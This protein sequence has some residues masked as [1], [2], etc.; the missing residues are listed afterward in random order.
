LYTNAKSIVDS[1]DAAKQTTQTVKFDIF[2][3]PDNVD[4][5]YPLPEP[6]DQVIEGIA[7][8][9]PAET[10]PAASPAPVLLNPAAKATPI[11]PASGQ[12]T[13]PP[14]VASI[15][16]HTPDDAKLFWGDSPVL[17]TGPIRYFQSSQLPSGGTVSYTFRAEMIVADGHCGEECRGEVRPGRHMDGLCGSIV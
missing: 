2:R 15:T 14:G 5:P 8:T 11:P 7:R 10:A 9:G 1:L 16:V 4:L 3:Q 12:P 6:I 13:P 17:T